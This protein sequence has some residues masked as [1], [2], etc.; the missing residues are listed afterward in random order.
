[1][2]IS[3]A[4]LLAWSLHAA[5]PRLVL[6]GPRGMKVNA[7]LLFI[8]AGMALWI[9]QDCRRWWRDLVVRL[10]GLF[11]VLA[12]TLTLAELVFH[13]NLGIDELF[14]HDDTSL[15]IRGRMSVL[16]T[17]SFQTLGSALFWLVSPS[18]IARRAAQCLMLATLLISLY[19]IVGYF[20][21]STAIYSFDNYGSMALQTAVNFLLLSVVML[22]ARDDFELTAPFRKQ[23]IGGLLVKTALPGL[24][25]LP[26]ILGWLLLKGEQLEVYGIAS[27]VAVYAVLTVAVFGRVV[28]Y[29]ACALNDVDRQREESRQRE[30]EMREL[31]SLDPLTGVLN[32]RSL[33]DRFEREWSR[34]IRHER[35]LACVML[36]VDEFKL[37]NDTYGHLSGDAVLKVIAR[38]LVQECRPCDIVARYGGEEFCIVV[39]E[40]NEAGAY[41]LAERVRRAL[42]A[43]PIHVSGQAVH[44]TASLGVAERSGP[45][46]HTHALLERADRALL[47]AKR[48]GRNRVV[49]ASNLPDIN[50][51]DTPADAVALT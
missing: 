15:G 1:M 11:V 50:G 2:L 14:Y 51:L 33:W 7:A 17:V 23:R 10:C 6:L 29:S 22:Y 38:I 46:D 5:V 21:G 39:P 49:R 35:D 48:M 4:V 42:L 44:V 28:W 34:C 18:I 19:I 8:V 45:D 32:R 12:A 37:I 3:A 26:I 43:D 20:Y 13:C 27:G 25:A 30:Q 16:A 31:S 24:A 40:A 41:G 36:D 9:F 47:V